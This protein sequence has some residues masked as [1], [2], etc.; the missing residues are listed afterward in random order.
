M[1]RTFTVTASGYPQPTLTLQSTT[2]SGGHDFDADTGVLTYTPP[3]AD[4]GAPTFTFRASNDSGVATQIVTVSVAA[5]VPSAVVSLWASSTNATDFTAAWSAS[6]LA[7]GYRL[8]VSTEPT[9]QVLSG[10]SVQAVLASNAA[11][12]VSQ[13]SGDWSGTAL[14]GTNGY[15]QMLQA[16]S[17]IVSP[18][19]STV[20]YTNLTVDFWARTYGGGAASNIAVSI[21][22]DNGATWAALG[23]VAPLDSTFRAM[24]TL[25]DTAHLGHEQTRIRWQSPDASGTVG[26]GVKTLVIQGWGPAYA[27]SFVAGC[28]NLFV[29]GTSQTVTGL[30]ELT[31]YYFRVR[32]ENAAGT[33]ANSPA[34]NVT[35]LEQPTEPLTPFQEWLAGRDI[36]PTNSL[37]SEDA[38]YDEDGA[39]TY[40]EYLADTDPTSAGSVLALEGT[41]YNKIQAGGE[42]GEM[43]FTFPA[44]SARYYQLLYSADLFATLTN[45]L[46]WGVPDMVVTNAYTG[47]WFGTLRVLLNEP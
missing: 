35:T 7:T 9:F 5:G 17:E 24:T 22:T 1:A 13:I 33:S 25:T 47:T 26:V 20:G 30:V 45:N 6:V 46:G 32:A 21:S 8:D 42:T 18:A 4:V 40:E 11:T 10:G 2:A 19:F 39:T 34:A 12:D 38:D 43:R 31:T 36:D 29:A 3:E 14:A 37:F 23:T 15:V 27:P 28:Q 41:Y 16:S 44:S